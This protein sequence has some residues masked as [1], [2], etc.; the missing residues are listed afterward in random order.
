MA[1]YTKINTRSPY[2][3]SQAALSAGQTISVELYI[4]QEGGSEPASATYNLS[5][6][7]PSASM[8]TVFFDIAPYLKGYISHSSFTPVTGETATAAS[9]YVYCK[10]IVKRAGVTTQ[11]LYFIGYNG[12]GYFSDGANPVLD[13]NIMLDEGEYY[14]LKDQNYGA[15]FYFQEEHGGGDDWD[16]V[17]ECLDGTTA[18]VNI[19]MNGTENGHIPYIPPTHKGNGSRLKIYKDSVLQKT[20][21]FTEV[22]EPKYTP[23]ICDFVNKY[24]VWQT[25]IFFKVSKSKT[26]A[27]RSMYKMMPSNPTTFQTTN[28]ITQEFNINGQENITVNTGWVREGYSDVMQQILLSETIRLDNRPVVPSNT[29][30]ELKTSINDRMINYEMSFNY[31]N[32]LINNIQ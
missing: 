15:L 4:H 12:Y 30:L 20:F 7:A 26:Q 19:D 10:A 6:P 27:T 13:A 22:C 25:I 11:T 5:K 24:G 1:S 21:T 14:M 3:L 17:Y 2:M 29:Q 16:A 31:A 23:V 28:N 8:L 32:P 18:D 9:N